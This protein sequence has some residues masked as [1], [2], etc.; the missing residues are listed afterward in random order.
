MALDPH[1]NTSWDLSSTQAA[2]SY[3]LSHPPIHLQLSLSLYNP[4]T[5]MYLELERERIGEG[6]EEGKKDEEGKHQHH[7]MDTINTFNLIHGKLKKSSSHF[8]DFPPNA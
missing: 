2:P 3:P 6:I 1:V 5:R 7:L 4:R 8:L